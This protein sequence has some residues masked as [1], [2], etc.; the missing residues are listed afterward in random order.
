[1]SEEK[2]PVESFDEEGKNTEKEDRVDVHQ[3]FISEKNSEIKKVRYGREKKRKRSKIDLNT[4]KG[5]KKNISSGFFDSGLNNISR[6]N[7]DSNDNGVLNSI[8]GMGTVTGRYQPVG[9][10]EE[11]ISREKITNDMTQ[12]SEICTCFTSTEVEADTLDNFTVKKE[13][14]AVICQGRVELKEDEENG[15]N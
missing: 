13:N 10:N 1:M 6:S 7:G 2:N 11:T 15:L 5:K 12:Y 8:R 3:S 14:V 4:R 9:V